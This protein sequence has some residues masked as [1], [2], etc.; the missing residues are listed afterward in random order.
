MMIAWLFIAFLTN[1]NGTIYTNFSAIE[2]A[3]NLASLYTR[4]F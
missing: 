2:L 3:G 1:L 4:K